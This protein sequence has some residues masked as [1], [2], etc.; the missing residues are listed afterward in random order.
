MRIELFDRDGGRG[1][2]ANIKRYLFSNIFAVRLSSTLAVILALGAFAGRAEAAKKSTGRDAL[3]K[4]ARK[5]CMMGD[6]QKGTE[7][8]SDLFIE[9]KDITYVYNQARCLEQNHRWEEALDR[10]LEYQ[11]KTPG[12]D[13]KEKNEVEQ[14]I[15]ECKSHLQEQAAVAPPPVVPVSPSPMAQPAAPVVVQVAAPASAPER[16]GGMGLRVSG[17][18]VG[19]VGLGA[20]A[21]GVLLA[22]KTRTLTDELNKTYNRDKAAKRDS[23]ETW[24]WV[25]YGV[26]A[27]A[28]VTG[29]T[30]CILGWRAGK[31]EPPASAVSILPILSPGMGGVL[32]RGAY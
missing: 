14:H 7:I 30:L 29:T 24:G 22:A 15:V 13:E 16:T 12:V 10:F 6:Y 28:L 21:T 27:A 25:S 32:L 11:R 18:A 3:E 8:L 1:T 31:S 23:Y 17:I 2:C 19:V 20:I 4:S 26:G 5:A 9:T